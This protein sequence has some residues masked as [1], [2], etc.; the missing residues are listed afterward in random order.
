MRSFAVGGDA[1]TVL[2]VPAGDQRL[3]DRTGR[4]RLAT[5]DPSTRSVCVRGDLQPPLL[6]R[7]VLHE[8]SHTI[9]E[10][11]GLLGRLRASVP[12]SSWVAAEEW[13][14]SLMEGHS[15]EA[16]M[17]AAEVLGR[18]PCVGGTCLG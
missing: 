10:S 4:A 1:W 2:R 13:A 5:T 12:R 8:V 16:L 7:V 6:D 18:P 17:A 15:I 3:I 11:H 9:A 14:A